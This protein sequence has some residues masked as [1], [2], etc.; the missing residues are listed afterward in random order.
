M[1]FVP[2]PPWIGA[3]SPC[4]S[5]VSPVSDLDL[6]G[7]HGFRAEGSHLLILSSGFT[8]LVPAVPANDPGEIG[9][10]L[11]GFGSGMA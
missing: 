4:S 10:N 2:R 5:S 3:T 7:V 8:G 1:V 11:R 9:A 6:V